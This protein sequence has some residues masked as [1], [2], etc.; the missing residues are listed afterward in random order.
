M[1]EGSDLQ[2]QPGTWG[3]AAFSPDDSKLI[4]IYDDGQGFEWSATPNAWKQHACAVA[5]RNLTR[6]EWARFVTARRYAPVC[7]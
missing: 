2:G 5:G 3:N 4:A 1:Q 6:E 7:P